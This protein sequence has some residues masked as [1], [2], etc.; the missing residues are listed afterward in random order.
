M[1]SDK[2]K[3]TRSLVERIDGQPGLR[4][5]IEKL[6]TITE[7]AVGTPDSLDDIEELIIQEGHNLQKC[8]FQNWANNKQ[9]VIQD[10]SHRDADLRQSGKKK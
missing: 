10:V 9:Q 1:M 4:E 6:V 5:Q 8:I 7:A 2:H 3:D